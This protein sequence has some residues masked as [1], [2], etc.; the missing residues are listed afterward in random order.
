[1]SRRAKVKRF[2]FASSSSIYGDQVKYPLKEHFLPN[3]MSP[4]ALQKLIGEQYVELY[5]N[6]YG[7]KTTILR[8][9]NVYGDRMPYGDGAYSLLLGKFKHQIAMGY[10]VTRYG[11]GEQKRDFT[12]IDD[13]VDAMMATILYHNDFSINT[14]FNIGRS[15][16]KTVNEIIE[17]FGCDYV[18]VEPKKEPRVTYADNTLAKKILQ[19][20]TK[21]DV[22][23][24]IKENYL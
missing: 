14:T 9:F 3:P 23:E 17:A 20:N 12:H 18:E 8:F 16:P 22:I 10:P 5:R 15:D 21:K 1:M 24:W 13:V 4:Y 6:I 11:D 7:M 2:V 19:W